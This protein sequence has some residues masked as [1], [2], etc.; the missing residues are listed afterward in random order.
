MAR[1]CTR[2]GCGVYITNCVIEVLTRAL[3]H[4]TMWLMSHAHPDLD[5]TDSAAEAPAD[6]AVRRAEE[7]L[8]MLRELAEIGMRLTRAV[9]RR[10][11]AEAEA[12]EAPAAAARPAADRANSFD[13]AA[14]FSSLSRA[15]RLTLALEA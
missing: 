6:P 10:A 4:A 12:V 5:Q 14:A 7:R 3:Q 8:A 2:H 1:P 13:P 9:E 11:L 15:V